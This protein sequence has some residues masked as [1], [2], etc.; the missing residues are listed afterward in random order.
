MSKDTG[1]ILVNAVY[2]KGQWKNKFDISSTN[3]EPFYLVDGQ[4]KNVSMMHTEGNFKIGY[5]PEA[6]A[7][8]I[9]LP[10]AVNK[11][12]LIQIVIGNN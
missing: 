10:Y 6:D 2:F 3:S 11:K 7:E 5:L 12:L 8:F 9:E 4:I 1:L